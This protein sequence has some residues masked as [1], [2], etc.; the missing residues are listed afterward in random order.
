[1][2]EWYSTES[3]YAP[4]AREIEPQQTAPAAP[5][6]K[7]KYAWLWISGG[8]LL[9]LALIASSLLFSRGSG[10]KLDDEILPSSPAEDTPE[11]LP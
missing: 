7:K 8:V 11:D 1:M 3:W 6:K 5:V 9:A 10:P 4:L 2:N